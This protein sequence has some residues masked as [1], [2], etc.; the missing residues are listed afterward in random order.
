MVTA[1]GRLSVSIFILMIAFQF[2]LPDLV[3]PDEGQVQLRG[4]G[5]AVRA[6]EDPGR[7][8]RLDQHWLADL[9]TCADAR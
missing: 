6:E 2:Q 8:H 4:P 9:L 5:C 1:K 7:K 3:R